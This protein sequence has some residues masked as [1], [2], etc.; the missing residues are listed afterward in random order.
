MGKGLE[1]KVLAQK[2]KA[3]EI[4]EILEENAA[5]AKHPL[6]AAEK[7]QVMEEIEANSLAYSKEL[8][9][10][11]EETKAMQKKAFGHSLSAVEIKHV[12]QFEA[13]VKDLATSSPLNNL[14]L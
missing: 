5:K 6:S 10:E 7:K 2:K 9:E 3:L 12:E 4:A 13:R 14:A 8:Q 1:A 11:F